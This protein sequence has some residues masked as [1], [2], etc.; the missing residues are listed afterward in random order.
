M[1]MPYFPVLTTMALPV[2]SANTT[3][4]TFTTPESSASDAMNTTNELHDMILGSAQ[5]TT[6]SSMNSLP[7]DT[8]MTNDVPAPTPSS[9]S[10]SLSSYRHAQSLR[11]AHLCAKNRRKRYL[12]VHPEYFSDPDLEL[13]DPILYDRWIRRFKSAAE[14]EAEGRAKGLSGLLQSHAATSYPEERR[15]PQ[16]AGAGS[17]QPQLEAQGQTNANTTP[18]SLF[19]FSQTRGPSGNILPEDKN[20]AP[21]DKEQG[22]RMWED[23]MRQRFLMGWDADFDYSTVDGN[24]AYNDPEGERDREEAYFDSLEDGDEG[25]GGGMSSGDTGIQDY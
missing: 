17:S 16:S 25:M 2:R 24:E 21:R 11:S 15:V 22:R 19:S 8:L 20:E 12:E 3:P 4:N 13:A 10:A 23:E 9:L 6:D 5:L 7:A 18:Y 1:S 14:R